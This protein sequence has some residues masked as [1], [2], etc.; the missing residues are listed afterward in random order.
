MVTQQQQHH[1]TPLLLQRSLSD[2][3]CARINRWQGVCVCCGDKPHGRQTKMT[4]IADKPSTAVKPPMAVDPPMAVEPLTATKLPTDVKLS[5]H[6]QQ[7]PPHNPVK[8]ACRHR[9]P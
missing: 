9:L 3:T 1:T 2:S 7:T 5:N 8:V 4:P 6:Q